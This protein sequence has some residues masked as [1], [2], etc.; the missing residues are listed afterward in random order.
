MNRD[1]CFFPKNHNGNIIYIFKSIVKITNL[2]L[3]RSRNRRL[4]FEGSGLSRQWTT[5]QTA[6]K[7]LRE[8]SISEKESNIRS[9]DVQE[10]ERERKDGKS[11]ATK[12]VILS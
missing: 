6:V 11:F 7:E 10:I 4:F 5:D 3:F 8:S 1:S 12:L 2:L 9:G